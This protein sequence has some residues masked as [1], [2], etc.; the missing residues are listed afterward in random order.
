MLVLFFSAFAQ[1]LVNTF[2]HMVR[3]RVNVNIIRIM[4]VKRR[5]SDRSVVRVK[6]YMSVN[7]PELFFRLS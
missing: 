2:I 5:D 6:E 7:F 1:H 4:M 3:I